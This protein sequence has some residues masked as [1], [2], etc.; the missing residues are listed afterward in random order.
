[1]GTYWRM[2]KERFLSIDRDKRVW[3]GENGGNMPRLKRFLTDER[4]AAATIPCEAW[5]RTADVVEA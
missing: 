1:M 5:N 2:K 3:W 4:V